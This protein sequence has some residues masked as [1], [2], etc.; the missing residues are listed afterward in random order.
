[1]IERKIII[2][3]ITSTEY[4]QKIKSIWDSKLIESA[5]AKRLAGWCWEYFDKYGKAPGKD[6]EAIFYSRAKSSKFPK[7]I[8]EEIEQEILP[9]LSK[10]YENQDKNIEYLIQ[11]TNKHFSERH[12]AIYS[13]DIQSLLASGEL[14][15]AEKMVHEFR[16]LGATSVDLNKFI[17]NVAQVRQHKRPLPTLLM[18]PWLRAGQTT[19]VYGTFGV[20]KSLLTILVGYM[21]GL[22]EYK[23]VQVDKW[24]VR[25]PTGCLYIDGELG[26]Q[27]MEE[28]IKQ[29]EWIGDQQGKYRI[30]ILS[31]PEYQIATE[32][33]FY[34]SER[35][36]QLQIISWLKKHPD[37]KL[38]VL[39]SAST[40]FGLIEENSNSEWNNKVNPF[41]RDLRAMGIACLLL[42]H[43]GKDNKKGLRGA[44]AMGAMAHN[45]YRL[46]NHP[47]KDTDDG[48]AW[49]SLEKDKQRASGF[50]FRTFSIHFHK[51]EDGTHWEI[52]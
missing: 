23:D 10:E 19:I 48:E 41:L 12:L 11:E 2:G 50:Q 34:L 29:F 32:D 27:E 43:A 51:E 30:R 37:Y 4:L 25:N 49:F 3:L 7:Q 44:S 42:H 31:L 13:E 21:M 46:T 36:N 28:R 17:L 15:Q 14:D 26:Q 20:G 39:D 33:T 24:Q 1:M 52:T 22:K 38:I 8:L 16:P 35:R 5:V 6:I 45:I 18:K 40:L 9:S 47:D